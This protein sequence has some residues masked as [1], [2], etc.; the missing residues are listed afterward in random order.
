MKKIILIVCFFMLTIS[1]VNAQVGIRNFGSLQIY[2]GS[3]VTGWNDFTNTNTATLINNGTLYFKNNVTNNEPGMSAG[4]GSVYLN[5]TV[6]QSINGSATFKVNNLITDNISGIILNNNLSVSGAHTFSNGLIVT[7]STPNYLIY[8]AGSSYS[9]NSDSRHINGWVKKMG[10]TNFVFPVGD[11]S[12]ERSVSI[13]NLSLSG[14]FNCKYNTPTSNTINLFSP[15]AFVKANEYW[16]LDKVSGGTAQV[17]LNWD[18]SKVAMDNVLIGDILSSLYTG[19][20]WTSTGGSASGNVTTTGTITSNAIGSFGSLTFGYT[21][22]PVP[23]KL[24]SFSA[25]RASGIS[26]LK[27]VTENEYN[28]DH[29]D[30][31]RSYDGINY[32]NIGNV[33]ARNSNSTQMYD[34]EDHASLNGIAYY[35]IKSVDIDKKSSISKIVAV[36]ENTLA[37]NSFVI[38]NPARSVITILNKSNESGPFEYSLY[39]TSGQL[40]LKGRTAIGINGGV[41]IPFSQKMSA[42]IYILE[43]KNDKITFLQKILVEK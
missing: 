2:T 35:R 24:L 8:E 29:F 22:F 40:F 18:H 11:A 34:Y 23:L 10:N 1:V 16:Q 20:N 41:A 27:W 37:S 13:S 17:I 43:I 12:Y 4:T 32:S 5:G 31:Q 9:G 30:V 42:G 25:V 28:V 19:G 14:E 36:S 7:S 39:N 38:L 6:V 21:S 33:V 15:I 26:F 3:S